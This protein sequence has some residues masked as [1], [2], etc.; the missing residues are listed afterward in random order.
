MFFDELEQVARIAQKV[1]TTVFVIEPELVDSVMKNAGNATFKNAIVVEPEGGKKITI[2]QVRNVI[3]MTQNRQ[4]RDQFFVF[5]R[6]EMLG[7]EAE[8][9]MLKLLEEPRD[10]YHFVLFTEHP[11]MLLSTILSRSEIYYLRKEHRLDCPPGV[12]KDVL[13][14]AKRLLTLSRGNDYVQFADELHKKKDERGFALAVLETAIE[15]AFKSFLM[16]EKR[17]FLK[18]IPQMIEAYDRIK[19]NGNVRLHLVADLC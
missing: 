12:E 14:M 7:E 11:E 19:S 4:T 18:K 8:N 13:A 5:K 15:L 1:G 17:Q 16:T 10:K 9:A 3:A 6:A 2:E